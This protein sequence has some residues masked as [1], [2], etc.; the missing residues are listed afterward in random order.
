MKRFFIEQTEQ[1]VIISTT[2]PVQ[3]TPEHQVQ[4][5]FVPQ[6]SQFLQI[7]PASKNRVGRRSRAPKSGHK[8]AHRCDLDLRYSIADEIDVGARNIRRWRVKGRYAGIR[9]A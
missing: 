8:P 2:K 7:V 5:E 3:D 1:P 4:A 6:R 9:A